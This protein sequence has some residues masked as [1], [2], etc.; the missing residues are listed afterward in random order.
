MLLG[1]NW[2]AVLAIAQIVGDI[3]VFLS[4]VYVGIQIRD[5]AR[6]RRAQTTHQQAAAYTDL[7]CKL[8]DNGELADIYARG[9][10]DI[11]SL[12]E[13]EIVRFI[14]FVSSVFRVYEDAYL[15]YKLGHLDAQV[16][17]GMQDPLNRSISMPGLRACWRQQATMFSA[18]F[19]ALVET[20]LRDHPEP[21]VPSLAEQKSRLKALSEAEG[22]A[23]AS[24]GAVSPSGKGVT[25]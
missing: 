22:Q 11:D 6:A 24:S 19:R 5:D 17:L 12:T 13:N 9:V 18:D 15:Q 23:H 25:G 4:L 2:D 16:W 3:L 7:L 21:L 1:I 20:R 8:A 10:R 14:M